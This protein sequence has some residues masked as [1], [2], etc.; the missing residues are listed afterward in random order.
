MK[1]SRLLFLTAALTAVLMLSGCASF[2]GMFSKE[3][4]AMNAAN[5]ARKQGNYPLAIEKSV[6]ATKL[7]PEYEK[8]FT[9]I[10]EAYPEGLSLYKSRIEQNK[11]SS[12]KFAWDSIHDD[13]DA[14]VKMTDN[15]KAATLPVVHPVEGW[16]FDPDIKD[17]TSQ[18]KNAKAKAIEA[19]YVEG[20][21]LSKV[22]DWNAKKECWTQFQIASDKAGKSYKDGK[23]IAAAAY[24]KEGLKRSK[25]PTWDK[26]EGSFAIFSSLTKIWGGEYNKHFSVAAELH[27]QHGKTME[28]KN[29]RPGYREAVTAYELSLKWVPNYKN[30]DVLI[31]AAKMKAYVCYYVL[32]TSSKDESRMASHIA[33]GIMDKLKA[34]DGFK[35]FTDS[36]ARRAFNSETFDAYPS[37]LVALEENG[38]R[39]NA[40]TS[41]SKGARKVGAG[42]ILT[43]SVSRGT[44]RNPGSSAVSK[45]RY[46]FAEYLTDYKGRLILDE[47]N[48]TP[49]MASPGM[50]DNSNLK[51]SGPTTRGFV[52]GVGVGE[53]RVGSFKKFPMSYT[54][55]TLKA[56]LTT[57]IT[58][59]IY[60]V[61]RSKVLDTYKKSYTADDSKS[62]KDNK[63]GNEGIFSSQL[64]NEYP[65]RLL[66]KE[67]LRAESIKQLEKQSAKW[68]AKKLNRYY[69]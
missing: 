64:S 46:S 42:T 9:F 62:W 14:L 58:L 65:K 33:S 3:G 60:D 59:R 49:I 52:E 28:A 41:V 54:Q 20:V 24:Y 31:A 26:R 10:R 34:P 7:N 23:K 56:S 30:T 18:R 67:E 17:Y 32:E 47:F 66:S 43:V 15:I 21:R 1:K 51:N 6:E 12:K 22:S 11:H 48:K 57:T 55:H 16:T 25:A 45:V 2:M 39:P 61:S 68:A 19:H 36:D 63:S 4:R 27:Y 40:I 44:Y 69:P 5:S 37:V 13:Y 38:Y 8:A 53:H 50:Y 35:N 29:T